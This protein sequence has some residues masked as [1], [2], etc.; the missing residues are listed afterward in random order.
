MSNQSSSIDSHLGL[1]PQPRHHPG[2]CHGRSLGL[3]KA[4]PSYIIAQLVGGVA[5]AG[6]LFTIA[7]LDLSNATV[8]A[9]AT[10]PLAA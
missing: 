7:S 10:K 9:F 3:G 6:L 4:G 1:P 2:A 5:A 8:G